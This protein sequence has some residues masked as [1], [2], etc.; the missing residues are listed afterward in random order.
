MDTDEGLLSIPK[1]GFRLLTFL[2][3]QD[4]QPDSYKIISFIFHVLPGHEACFW[5]YLT[6]FLNSLHAFHPLNPVLVLSCY[7]DHRPNRCLTLIIL[8]ACWIWWRLSVFLP[9]FWF[10][11]WDSSTSS[12]LSQFPPVTSVFHYLSPQFLF[13]IAFFFI[14]IHDRLLIMNQNRVK[15]LF[16]PH[17]RY[18]SWFPLF[19]CQLLTLLFGLFIGLVQFLSSFCFASPSQGV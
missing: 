8:L 13:A 11:I 2:S 15:V 4:F 6:Y 18:S 16:E 1:S 10:F 14:R 17:L 12:S 19:I 5:K 3:N 9:P 7:L